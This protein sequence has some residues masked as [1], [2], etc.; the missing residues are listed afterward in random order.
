MAHTNAAT[1]VGRTAVSVAAVATAVAVLSFAG[2]A[3]AAPSVSV[4]AGPFSDGQ[5]ITVTGSGFPAKVTG[6][7]QI[8]ECSDPGGVLPTDPTVGC[9]G[10]TVSP[11]TIPTDA[12]GNF[13]T[14]YTLTLLSTINSNILCDAT[15]QCV[16]WVG[17]DYNAAFLSG[18]HAFSSPFFIDSAPATT[19]ESPLT[20]ALPVLA[21]LSA[22]TYVFVRRRRGSRHVTT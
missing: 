12:S 4:P 10:T 9:D 22:G 16:L 17:T 11:G 21:A 8:I 19:P 20:V 1:K 18:P 7:L 5:T 3:D 6:G 13:S 15:D 2:R 14:S